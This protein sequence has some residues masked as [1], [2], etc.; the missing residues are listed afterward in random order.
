MVNANSSQKKVTLTVSDTSIKFSFLDDETYPLLR[1]KFS[2]FKLNYEL[3]DSYLNGQWDGKVHLI[4]RNTA[5]IGFKTQLC[6]ELKLLG[7]E[8]TV[9]D[10]REIPTAYLT[11]PTWKGPT[12][13][14][15]QFQAVNRFLEHTTG[16]L[17]IRTGEGKAHIAAYLISH[18]GLTTTFVTNGVASMHQIA[19]RL[20]ESV[21]GIHIFKAGGGEKIKESV[22]IYVEKELKQ[23][24]VLIGTYQTLSQSFLSYASPF[25]IIDECHNV[26]DKGLY[27][28]AQK[29]HAYYRLGLSAFPY[30]EDNASLKIN[31]QLGN[32]I[33]SKSE[34]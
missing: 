7:Y 34:V 14:Y 13:R 23:P 22:P 5:P 12:L 26:A 28:F 2:Y 16:I 21:E 30:R 18:L 19:D 20:K 3:T 1:S 10:T 6:E 29:S 15:Y 11:A 8:V 24:Y 4:N 33:F 31:A 27:Q 32:V 25:L 17:Q 9:V